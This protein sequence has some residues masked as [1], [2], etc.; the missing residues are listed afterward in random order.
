MSKVFLLQKLPMPIAYCAFLMTCSAFWQYQQA[1]M[2]GISCLI[3]D[4][5]VSIVEFCL[6]CW[7]NL[8]YLSSKISVLFSPRFT[9]S[10]PCI[11]QWADIHM[12]CM[13]CRRYDMV[14]WWDSWMQYHVGLIS[15]W[16]AIG[17]DMIRLCASL[18]CS[19]MSCSSRIMNA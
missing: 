3:C 5:T 18:N 19:L 8:D 11:L 13:G 4:Q 16:I 6:Y 7:I 9:D 12:L 17:D 2:S 10:R 14:F 1:G 15:W